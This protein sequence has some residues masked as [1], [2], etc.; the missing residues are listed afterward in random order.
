MGE[1][2]LYSR[3][4][5]ESA[6]TPLRGGLPDGR[7]KATWEKGIQ[8]SMAQGLSTKIISVIKW[9]RTSRLLLLIKNSL[10][11]WGRAV[12]GRARLGR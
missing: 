1:V 7:C 6:E 2:P 5:T 10:S 12:L 11:P 3:S 4:G 8:T 9:I